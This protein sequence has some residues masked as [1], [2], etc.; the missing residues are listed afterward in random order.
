MTKSNF[1]TYPKG[2]TALE[3]TALEDMTCFPSADDS[4]MLCSPSG[5]ILFVASG[6][7][8]HLEEDLVGRSLNDVFPDPLAAKIVAMAHGGQGHSFRTKLQGKPACC[9]MSPQAEGMLITVLFTQEG[10]LPPMTLSTAELLSR[11][12]SSNLGTMFAAWESLPSP[13][14]EKSQ[15]A[16]SVLRQG[17]YRLMRLGRNLL[18][19]TRAEN[20]QLDL[21]PH[22]NDLC[23]LFCQVCQRVEPMAEKL[24]IPLSWECPSEPI[25]CIFDWDWIERVILGLLSNAMKYTRQ[26]NRIHLVL[27]LRDS[28]AVLTVTDQG[29]GISPSVLPEIFSRPPEFSLARGLMVG[30]A[31][32][33]LPLSRSVLQLHGGT[34]VLSSVPDQGTTVTLSL[35]LQSPLTQTALGAA[36]PD[37][38]SGFDH[39]LLELSTVLPASFYQEALKKPRSRTAPPK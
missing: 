30:G 11:E 9:T 22:T 28:R 14:D 39:A 6:L 38:A 25:S 13:R 27:S 18:D 19:C 35:P 31:G 37:Y 29:R 3:H 21:H 15:Y 36:F 2:G 34:F 20:G 10:H 24:G 16:K 1:H 23:Q 17:M 8:L 32:F 7:R 12:I 5:R 33:G 26:D 4:S